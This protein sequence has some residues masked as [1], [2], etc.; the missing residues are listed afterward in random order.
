MHRIAKTEN[1][2]IKRLWCTSYK[3]LSRRGQFILHSSDFLSKTFL[4]VSLV[5]VMPLIDEW[6]HKKKCFRGFRPGQTQT[7]L[8][9]DRRELEA[10]SLGCMLTRNHTIHLAKTKPQISCAVNLISSRFQVNEKTHQMDFLIFDFCVTEQ[11]VLY[12]TSAWGAYC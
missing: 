8:Y 6:H 3:A 1:G 7:S 12:S 9:N 11:P 2:V 10:L 4:L 5:S